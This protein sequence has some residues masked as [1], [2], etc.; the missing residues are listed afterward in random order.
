MNL[1]KK[2]LKLIFGFRYVFL[3]YGRVKISV[4]LSHNRFIRLMSNGF[5][6]CILK[7]QEGG[8]STYI[9]N[10]VFMETNLYFY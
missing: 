6:K 7:L 5:L 3:I 10:F 4:Y 9:I 8:L 1:Y 2:M